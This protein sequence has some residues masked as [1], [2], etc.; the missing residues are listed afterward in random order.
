MTPFKQSPGVP[1]RQPPT[2]TPSQNPVP[3]WGPRAGKGTDKAPKRLEEVGEVGR[4]EAGAVAAASVCGQH[5]LAWRRGLSSCHPSS[6]IGVRRDGCPREPGQ[7]GNQLGCPR[8]G[9]VRAELQ[10]RGVGG[11]GSSVPTS[12]RL[13]REHTAHP[14]RTL[15]SVLPCCCAQQ[16]PDAEGGAAAQPVSAGGAC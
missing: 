11:G 10:P 14:N 9:L 13:H 8:S 5:F 12:L 15:K 1:A 3:V 7:R 16:V 4:S 2:P 6:R